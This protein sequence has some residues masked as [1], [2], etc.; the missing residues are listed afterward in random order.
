MTMNLL[1]FGTRTLTDDDKALIAEAAGGFVAKD[2]DV[3]SYAGSAQ[4]AVAYILQHAELV[5]T[6]SPSV[7]S[8]GAIMTLIQFQSKVML[9][10]GSRSDYVASGSLKAFK[11]VELVS[12]DDELFKNVEAGIHESALYP[13]RELPYIADY[14]A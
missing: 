9:P 3:G 7:E 2:P 8:R 6:E 12:I 5:G 10:G 4:S 11:F 1:N 14:K 13:E